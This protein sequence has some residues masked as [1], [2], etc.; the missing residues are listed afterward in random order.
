MYING[1]SYIRLALIKRKLKWLN[2]FQTKQE[3][4]Q[5]TG[6]TKVLHNDKRITSQRRHNNHK[7]VCTQQHGIKMCEGKSGQLK[8]EI[9]KLI[10]RIG[11]FDALPAVFDRSSRQKISKNMI[12]LKSATNLFEIY[13]IIHLATGECTFFS[14]C[15]EGFPKIDHT[16]NHKTHVNKFIK[17]KFLKLC[18]QAIINVN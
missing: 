3:P 10:I 5:F 12:D 8:E 15:C 17:E 14:S 2:Q 13:R 4:E 18:S 9:N 6:I 1:K 11:D 7:C 16:V